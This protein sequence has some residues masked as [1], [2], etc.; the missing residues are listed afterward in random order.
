MPEHLLGDIAAVTERRRKEG[1]HEN[2]HPVT[3]SSIIGSRQFI[4]LCIVTRL[5][6]MAE[7][8]VWNPSRKTFLARAQDSH[9][10]KS[11]H[12]C[13]LGQPDVSPTPFLPCE[14]RK[15]AFLGSSANQ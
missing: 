9:S 11:R 8:V 7:S 5:R 13:F 14:Y 3:F 15:K 2:I 6:L 4:I 12:S 10:A 1:N